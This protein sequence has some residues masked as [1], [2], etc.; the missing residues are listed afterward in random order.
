[1]LA[2]HGNRSQGYSTIL[3]CRPGRDTIGFGRSW[4]KST[5]EG[6]E[7]LLI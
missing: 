5:C 1:M 2:F 6:A 7:G 3:E 4:Y